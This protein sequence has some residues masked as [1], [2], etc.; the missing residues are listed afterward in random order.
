M[1]IDDRAAAA[2]QLNNARTTR[3]QLSSIDAKLYGNTKTL[4]DLTLLTSSIQS[5]VEAW[6]EQVTRK[7]SSF[8]PKISII[9]PYFIHSIFLTYLGLKLNY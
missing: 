4:I 7:M 6:R 9:R 2:D 3:G 1:D 5:V 8:K